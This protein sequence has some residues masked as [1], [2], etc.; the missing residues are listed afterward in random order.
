MA[1]EWVSVNDALPRD[2]QAVLIFVVDENCFMDHSVENGQTRE[3]WKYSA[4]KFIRLI[5]QNEPNNLKP[6]IWKDFGAG[7][8][9]GQDVSHWAALSEPD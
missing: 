5:R 2:G 3:K 4:A 6:Y 8:H 7:S 9:F 1:I